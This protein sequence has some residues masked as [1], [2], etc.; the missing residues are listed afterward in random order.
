VTKEYNN[1]E[2]NSAL[3]KTMTLKIIE[4][5]KVTPLK[6]TTLKN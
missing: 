1:I 2:N 5:K 3:K 4:V 6:T